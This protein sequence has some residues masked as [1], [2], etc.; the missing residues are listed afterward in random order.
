[1]IVDRLARQPLHDEIAPAIVGHT[2][3][4][5]ADDRWMRQLRKH[6]DLVLEAL[7]CEL[8]AAVQQL[9]RNGAVGLQIARLED[10]TRAAFADLAQQLEAAQCEAQHK[11]EY[12]LSTGSSQRNQTTKR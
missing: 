8:V 12:T 3:R 7:L 9:D 1:M 11:P 6:R 10:H 4:D 2:I 5:V